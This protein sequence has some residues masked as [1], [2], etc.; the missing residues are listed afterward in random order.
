MMVLYAYLTQPLYL[1]GS[2]L[3]SQLSVGLAVYPFSVGD[4]M[5]NQFLLTSCTCALLSVLSLPSMAEETDDEA[6][7]NFYFSVGYTMLE[8]DTSIGNLGFSASSGSVNLSGAVSG[9][10]VDVSSTNFP[11]LQVGYRFPGYELWSIQT[12]LAVPGSMDITLNES[13]QVNGLQ[14]PEITGDL[15]EIKMASPSVN[16]VRH[17]EVGSKFRPYVGAG[18]V[19]ITALDAEIT[20]STLKDY[21]NPQM[22]ISDSVGVLFQVGAEY[23]L[24]SQWW[25]KGDIRYAT[26]ASADVTIDGLNIPVETDP[27]ELP[28]SLGTIRG[29]GTVDKVTTTADIS[30]MALTV[31]LGYEF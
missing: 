25:L 10:D 17:F 9:P 12:I 27:I 2:G 6:L 3:L 15:A 24:A 21:G 30:A 26:G 5:K 28:F 23:N 29:S 4:L 20:N 31:G 7:S 11:S 8:P 1:S 22:E 18:L 13:F 16:L 19:Y 14:L